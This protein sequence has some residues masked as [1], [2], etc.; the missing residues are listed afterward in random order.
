[1]EFQMALPSDTYRKEQLLLSLFNPNVA[2]NSFGWGN[3]K[4]LR[5]NI[6]DDVLYERLHEFR[7]YHYSGHRMTLAIQARLP[8]TVLESFVVECFSNVPCNDL[9]AD[10]FAKYSDH[11]FDSPN[12]TK[13]YYVEPVKEVLQV[14]ITWPLPSLL[15]MYK[16]KP[17]Q[18]VSWLIGHEGKGSLLSFLKKKV[19]AL[20]IFSGNDESGSDHNSIYSLFTITIVL[21]KN[22]LKHLDEVIAAV[23]SYLRLLNEMGPQERIFKEIQLVE[24]TSFKF[25]EE[26]DP[27]DFVEELAECMQ[28]YPP[29]Y[30]LAGG[31]L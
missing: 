28:V 22:G 24:D 11:I 5:D 23:Y 27:V 12:F 29:E 20:G 19:W 26:E 25:T 9:P 2:I 13:M 6:T 31:E 10:D 21:T 3:L 7:R 18:Y 16:S 14:D 8:I 15:H 30:Y 1:L 4:T 17:H